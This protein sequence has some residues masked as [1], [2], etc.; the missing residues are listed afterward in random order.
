MLLLFRRFDHSICR[1]AFSI[2]HFDHSIRRLDCP[3]RRSNLSILHFNGSIRLFTPFA[4][5]KRRLGN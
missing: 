5:K 1:L 4:H 3:I 2:R